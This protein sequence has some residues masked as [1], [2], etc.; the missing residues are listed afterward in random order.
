[1]WYGG[2]KSG[3]AAGTS[4]GG[5]GC[6]DATTQ[7]RRGHGRRGP[8]PRLRECRRHNRRPVPSPLSVHR[9]RDR[10]PCSDYFLVRSAAE[11]RGRIR[12][13]AGKV[14][15]GGMK[16]PSPGVHQNPICSPSLRRARGRDGLAWFMLGDCGSLDASS[17]LAPGPPVDASRPQ[18]PERFPYVFIALAKSVGRRSGA[19]K[20]PRGGPS[21]Q[22]RGCDDQAGGEEVCSP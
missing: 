16:A 8:R 2:I 15:R 13:I 17:N 20:K 1:M 9:S 10:G 19:M 11:P 6:R 18:G 21:P 5:R 3:D 4:S 12:S 7:N 14:I 22:E